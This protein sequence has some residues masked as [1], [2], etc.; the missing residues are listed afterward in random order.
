MFTSGMLVQIFGIKGRALAEKKLVGSFW[1]G[2]IV[3]IGASSPENSNMPGYARSYKFDCS[4]YDRWGKYM[5]E[6][7]TGQVQIFC[8]SLCRLYDSGSWI[9]RQ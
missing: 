3:A 2:T 7:L 4:D 5:V 8:R 6:N 1:G 9:T